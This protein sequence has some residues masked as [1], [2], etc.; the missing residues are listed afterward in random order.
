MCVLPSELVHQ[1]FL[2]T[3]TMSLVALSSVN[4]TVQSVS[5]RILYRNI[6]STSARNTVRCLKTLVSRPS[7]ASNTRSY[8][9]GDLEDDCDLLPSFFT[10]LS[11]A[12]HG[13]TRLTELAILLDGP[14]SD[15]LLGCPFRLTK[16]TSALHW[17]DP[18]TKW[19]R[20]QP[21]LRIALFCGKYVVGTKI[22]PQALPNLTRI[23][24]SPLI[25]AAV[26][27]GRPIK[28]VEICLVHPWLLN[29]GLMSTTMKIMT[30]STGPLSS[31]QIISHLGESTE[32][33][34]AAFG[35]IPRIVSTLDSLSLH[36][37]SGSVTIVRPS[38]QIVHLWN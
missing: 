29:E 31:L 35:V 30:F 26:V 16:L 6:G 34:L 7:L 15:I 13:M 36:A 32:D 5:E 9:I 12:L 27:P 19:V 18:F 33:T 22:N 21:E 4:H 1:I 17:D 37:V 3:D 10:L 24:A 25:L 2:Y 23:S 20:E 28:E 11:R 8:E 38:N 14:Y